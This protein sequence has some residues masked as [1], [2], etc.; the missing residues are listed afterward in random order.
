MKKK[1]RI[2][3]IVLDLMFPPRCPLCD[4]VI[5]FR[6]GD[7]CGKCVKRV[8]PV[9]GSVCMKCGKPL[10]EEKEYCFDCKT[11]KHLYVQ[12]ISAFE[13]RDIAASIYRFK[14]GGR[15]EYAAFFGRCM[16]LKLEKKIKQW[17]AEALVPVPVHP[18]RKRERGYNQ[19]G[20]AHV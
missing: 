2:S 5:E 6:K 18:S 11:K 15:Q 7:I 9:S 17:K 3:E 13:Y 8:K 12:G 10:E 16:A 19:I 1:Y 4:H 14:Y 20:R